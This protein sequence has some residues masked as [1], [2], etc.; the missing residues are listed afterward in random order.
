MV[1]AKNINSLFKWLT[2]KSQKIMKVRGGGLIGLILLLFILGACS[3]NTPTPNEIDESLDTGENADVSGI[4]SLMNIQSGK[5]LDLKRFP[6]DNEDELTVVQWSENNTSSQKWELKKIDNYYR[7]IN[8]SNGK[9]L[10][11]NPDNDTNGAYIVEAE[12]AGADTQHWIISYVDDNYYKIIS[13]ANGRSL[14]VKDAIC[15]DGAPIRQI[16][17]ANRKSRHWEL[18]DGSGGSANGQLT[19]KWVSTGVPTNDSSRI[20]NA[21]NEAVERYNKGNTWSARELTVEYN[22]SVP[23]ADANINGHIRFGANPGNQDEQTAL[24][25]I[26]HTYGIGTSSA[27]PGLIQDG[28]IVGPHVAQL[29]QLYDGDDANIYAGGI[30]FWPYG[31]NYQN[32]YSEVNAAR[33]VEIISAFVLDGTY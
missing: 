25:E 18:T 9:D 24:H 27:W 20:S 15:I 4:Y 5:L 33:H 14:D 26:A 12:Y 31:L 21:M 29:V 6:G 32:E 30:H 13:K 23:T 10:S 7:I 2:S 28:V 19:W 11:I 1:N 3:D 22:P 17:Y 16:K 8:Q